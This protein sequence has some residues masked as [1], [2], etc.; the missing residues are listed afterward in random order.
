MGKNLWLI[1]LAAALCVTACKGPEPGKLVQLSEACGKELDPPPNGELQRVSVE[2]YLA[3]PAGAFLMCS[4]TCGLELR[5]TPSDTKGLR[6]DVRIG[7][8]KNRMAKLPK[9]YQES[10]LVV[11]TAEGKE[12]S[13]GS[14]IRVTGRRLG[15]AADKTC[16]IYDVDL[17][18]GA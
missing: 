8:G 16:Q 11:T 5:A 3:I 15:T 6:I 17:I 9:K 12:V 2:G 1:C 18:Q 13:V 10:D 4:D 7:S 14:K